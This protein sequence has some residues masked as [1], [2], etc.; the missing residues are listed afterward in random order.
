MISHLRRVAAHVRGTFVVSQRRRVSRYRRLRRSLQGEILEA[1]QV[2]STVAASGPTG[3]ES[4]DMMGRAGDKLVTAVSTGDSFVRR[5]AGT[6][7]SGVKWQDYHSGDF[8]G[9]GWDD[10]VARAPNGAWWVGLK[11]TLGQLVH[12]GRLAQ[13]DGRRLEWRR[14]D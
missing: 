9:D 7:S 1:R 13:R 8:N 5:D 12:S 14:L 6:W 3:I 2:L 4:A 11:R 10:I